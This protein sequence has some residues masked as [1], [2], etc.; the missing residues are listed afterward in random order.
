[1]GLNAFKGKGQTDGKNAI[2]YHFL[3]HREV[4]K[5]GIFYGQADRK[6]GGRVNA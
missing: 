1:M 2:F 5:K 3:S 6:G 4:V